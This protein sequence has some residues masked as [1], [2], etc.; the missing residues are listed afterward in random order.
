MTI[1]SI[2]TYNDTYIIHLHCPT[3]QVEDHLQFMRES[4]GGWLS[5]VEVRKRKFVK[6][7]K[8]TDSQILSNKMEAVR[9][10]LLT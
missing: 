5:I 10:K 9:K 6:I 8:N 2:Y 3:D 1:P 4:L 7:N